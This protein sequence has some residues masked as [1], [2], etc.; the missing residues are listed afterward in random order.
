MSIGEIRTLA[1]S[2][3]VTIGTHGVTHT[4]LS[5]LTPIQQMEEFVT[6]KRQL[7]AWLDKKI[8]VYAYPYGNRPAYTRQSVRL[9]K[10]VG[11]SKAAANFPGQAHR[12]TDQYQIP[13]HMLFNYSG[14]TFARE[15]NK[16]WIE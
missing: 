4:A 15:I 7:E 16:L 9:C 1:K 13:R 12:W 6:S 10:E 14:D 5:S 8:S 11:F 2:P 3:L